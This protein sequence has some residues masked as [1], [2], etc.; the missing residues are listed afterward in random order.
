[1][2]DA[3][4][5]MQWLEQW[6]CDQCDKTLEIMTCSCWSKWSVISVKKSC[7]GGGWMM[8]GMTGGGRSNWSVISVKIHVL[9]QVG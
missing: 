9:A 5:D 2:D 4:H 3:N 8:K 6:E 1:M 7:P